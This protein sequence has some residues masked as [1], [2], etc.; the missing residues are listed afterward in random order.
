MRTSYL[1]SDCSLDEQGN[2]PAAEE[3]IIRYLPTPE[4]P[5]F[6][7]ASRR[8]FQVF[9][10][11]LD[12]AIRFGG[13]Q[14]PPQSNPASVDSSAS[15]PRQ[16]EPHSE[17]LG[18]VA[19]DS[20]ASNT[21]VSIPKK[22]RQVKRTRTSKSRAKANAIPETPGL[23][24]K[25]TVDLLAHACGC[26][27]NTAGA[28][29]KELVILGWIRKSIGRHSGGE[30]SGFWYR[31]LIPPTELTT[32]AEHLY[33]SRADEAEVRLR[34]QRQRIEELITPRDEDDLP[35]KFAT[36]ADDRGSS[37]AP[38]F[39]GQTQRQVDPAVNQKTEGRP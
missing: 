14:L 10:A 24:A 3:S 27:R 2:L 30:Y 23:E 39:E 15:T 38:D 5:G 33:N 7:L 32:T 29:L 13:P 6:K 12:H 36:Q 19:K 25:W 31:L 16:S 21:A 26:N 35:A 37:A 34:Q 1:S 18:E 4:T 22:R 28:T 20:S 17:N 9:L 11:L 8:V